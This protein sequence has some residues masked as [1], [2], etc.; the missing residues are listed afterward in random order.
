M[1][2]AAVWQNMKL[3]FEI[4]RT[5]DVQT[6]PVY[7]RAI[8]QSLIAKIVADFC[9]ECFDPPL[10]AERADGS[11]WVADGQT[12]VNALRELKISEFPARIFE[13]LGPQNEADIFVKSNMLKR[14]VKRFDI[15]HAGLAAGHEDTIAIDKMLR[16]Y[17]LS[18]KYSRAWPNISAVAKLY[19]AHKAGVLREILT[20]VTRCWHG[21]QDALLEVPI[22]GL[23]QFFKRFSSEADMNRCVKKWR[24]AG[25]TTMIQNADS[26]KMSG[27]SR[28]VAFAQSL[29]HKYNSG[30]RANI[31][32]WR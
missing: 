29:F 2:L 28:Y 32:Q 17:G 12:R 5:D 13:S 20:S 6:D 4:V 14:G 11:K 24:L 25:P 10:V 16:E 8:S 7:Q 26:A 22:G 19:D 27:G 23:L 3:R 31:L 21:N 9:P 30:L 18:V 1:K 15:Y